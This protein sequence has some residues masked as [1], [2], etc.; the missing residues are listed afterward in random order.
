MIYWKIL[1]AKFADD[2]VDDNLIIT[3]HV[4]PLHPAVNLIEDE[5]R[6]ESVFG[7]RHK[8][9]HLIGSAREHHSPSRFLD[10]HV[11]IVLA[12]VIHYRFVVEGGTQ[13]GGV[14]AIVA[15]HGGCHHVALSLEGETLA[16]IVIES[17]IGGGGRRVGRDEQRAE[18][19]FLR[20]VG[21]VRPASESLILCHLSLIVSQLAKI[22]RTY[23]RLYRFDKLHAGCKSSLRRCGRSHYAAI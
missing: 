15:A 2:I 21:G 7:I 22:S 8:V 14:V 16:T 17:L 5:T 4:V 6:E 3:E 10:I 23:L 11:L 20:L 1:L 13:S 12:A 19:W 18:W 9:N